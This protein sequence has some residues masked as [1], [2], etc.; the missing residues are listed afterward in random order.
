MDSEDSSVFPRVVSL[1]SD[2]MPHRVVLAAC[3]LG[4][5]RLVNWEWLSTRGEVVGAVS[6]GWRRRM[7][8]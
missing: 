1:S 7:V 3:Y 4:S 5:V 8:G 6:R 2:D